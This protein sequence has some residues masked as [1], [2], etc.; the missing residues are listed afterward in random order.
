MTGSKCRRKLELEEV[1]WRWENAVTGLRTS[2]THTGGRGLERKKKKKKKKGQSD[3]IFC[4]A[5]CCIIFFKKL[6]E[7]FTFFCNTGLLPS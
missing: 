3:K 1:D 4:V 5:V 2:K 6:R 7:H